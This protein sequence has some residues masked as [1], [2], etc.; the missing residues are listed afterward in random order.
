MGR[1]V[2][3]VEPFYENI[4]RIHKAAKEEGISD[5]IILVQNALSDKRNE[6]K[7]LQPASNN[8]GGQSLIESKNK[9]FQK[10]DMENDVYLVETVLLNDLTK[11]L[12][13]NNL[14]LKYDSAIL[15]LDIE[16]N[17]LL[18]LDNFVRNFLDYNVS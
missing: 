3:T 11:F 14:G 1:K 13:L 9:V 2:L 7:R 5:N 15:K 17:I 16:G 6:I 10:K 8:I 12:P 18:F 4:L